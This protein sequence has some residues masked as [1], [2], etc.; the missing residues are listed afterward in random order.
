MS[1]KVKFSIIILITLII[2]MAIGFEI[3]EISIKSRFNERTEFRGV[4]GF[5]G[6]FE[7]IL[8]PDTEQKPVIGA[9]LVKYHKIID[10][11]SNAGMAEV[12]K[13][14]DSMKVELKKNLKAEQ[15]ERLE[16]ELF[17]M[18][19]GPPPP[20]RNQ[21]N[22]NFRQGPNPDMGP[23]PNRGPAPFRQDNKLLKPNNNRPPENYRPPE[24][25]KR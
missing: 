14:F 7:D 12:S 10:S 1:I 25:E 6:R 5:V 11:T 8:R 13:L 15:I 18:K 24:M 23:D 16:N 4:R 21:G 2:G 3:S 17:W 19:N 9:I 22:P 20:P